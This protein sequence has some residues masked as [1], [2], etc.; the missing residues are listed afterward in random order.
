[1]NWLLTALA[2]IGF[3]EIILRM[4]VI[5]AVVRVRDIYA[6]AFRV[7]TSKVISDHWK[8]K[9]LPKYAF[10]L[11]GLTFRLAGYF[12]LAALPVIIVLILSRIFDLG[13]LEFLLSAIGII[14]ISVVSI[15]YVLARRLVVKKRV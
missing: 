8:E 7:I 3:V 10:I 1:M 9:A 15:V 14:Y 13:T 6:S 4:P 11:F 12:V 5:S 2:G